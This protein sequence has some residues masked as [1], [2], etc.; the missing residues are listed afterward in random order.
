MEA[1]LESAGLS[2]SS[3]EVTFWHNVILLAKKQVAYIN[4]TKDPETMALQNFDK[5]IED[6]EV[7]IQLWTAQKKKT[8]LIDAKKEDLAS[9]EKLKSLKNS[10]DEL[11]HSVQEFRGKPS[12][13]VH[14]NEISEESDEE[15]LD[16]E[17]ITKKIQDLQEE[18]MVLK[19]YPSKYSEQISN[20][21]QEIEQLEKDLKRANKPPS[22]K[23]LQKQQAQLMQDVDLKDIAKFDE[24]K[25]D[26]EDTIKTLAKFQRQN[27]YVQ[28]YKEAQENLVKLQKI[29]DLQKQMEKYLPQILQ[30]QISTALKQLDTSM[31]QLEQKEKECQSL[32]SFLKARK[33]DTQEIENDLKTIEKI[34]QLQKQLDS[35]KP[36]VD[37]PAEETDRRT[38]I[39]KLIEKL[40]KDVGGVT[41]DELLQEMKVYVKKNFQEEIKETQKKLDTLKQ[42]QEIKI[43]L[44]S[45][46]EP[47]PSEVIQEKI[48]HLLKE[49]SF[50]SLEQ[51]L[52]EKDGLMAELLVY[53]RNVKYQEEAKAVQ[54]QLEKI[55]EIEILKAE[56]DNLPPPTQEYLIQRFLFTLKKKGFEDV[57]QLRTK[58][59]DLETELLVFRRS[60]QKFSDEIARISEE[61]GTLNKL[62]LDVPQ[63]A[64][65]AILKPAKVE[66]AKVEPAKVE[67]AKVEPA[68]AGPAKV[69]PAKAGPAKV[70]PAKAGPAKAEPAIVEP[71]NVVATKS[72]PANVGIAAVGIERVK[73]EPVEGEQ[74][75][76]ADIDET[77]ITDVKERLLKIESMPD[78][79]EKAIS[80]M[81]YKTLLKRE[82]CKFSGETKMFDDLYKNIRTDLKREGIESLNIITNL[83]KSYESISSKKWVEAVAKLDEL[84]SYYR[85]I[86]KLFMEQLLKKAYESAKEITGKDVVFLL[87]GSGAGKSTT[88]HYLAGS[89]MEKDPYTGNIM[90]KEIKNETLKE[91]IVSGAARSITRYIRAIQLPNKA[92]LCD[93][94]GFGDTAGAEVDITNGIAIIKAI[95]EANS[96][97]LLLL[98]SNKSI[99]TR[100]EGI[101]KTLKILANMMKEDSIT[102]KTLK[103]IRFVFTRFVTEEEKNYAK[104]LIKSIVA[105]DGNT[106]QQNYKN[107][108]VELNRRVID[109]NKM[110]TIDPMDEAVLK[111]KL[112][113]LKKNSIKKPGGVFVSVIN[114]DSKD[115]LNNHISILKD[116]I[117][118]ALERGT[119]SDFDYVKWK[120]DEFKWLKDNL[121]QE[122][123]VDS[124][125]NFITELSKK[126]DEFQ[127]NFN[128]ILSIVFAEGYKIK[129]TDI[130][131]LVDCLNRSVYYEKN[132]TQEHFDH[133]A[134]VTA[135]G[136][137]FNIN[138]QL[139]QNVDN[140]LK[141]DY[142]KELNTVKMSL[143][144][145]Q[146]IASNEFLI[147]SIVNTLA[148]SFQLSKEKFFE[149]KKKFSLKADENLKYYPAFGEMVKKLLGVNPN[150]DGYLGEVDANLLTELSSDLEKL[151]RNNP[152]FTDV[153]NYYNFL[154][155]F[156][157]EKID[158]Q[159]R[160]RYQL[161]RNELSE[162][163]KKNIAE[164]D[165]LIMV[166]GNGSKFENGDDPRIS[167][168]KN[169]GDRFSFLSTILSALGSH[170]DTSLTNVEKLYNERINSFKDTYLKNSSINIDKIQLLDDGTVSSIE[171][172]L[173]LMSIIRETLSLRRHISVEEIDKIREQFLQS[174][175]RLFEQFPRVVEDTM[176]SDFESD[177]SLEELFSKMN[178]LRKI[179]LVRDATNG[180]YFDAKTNLKRK[181]EECTKTI[182]SG[183]NDFSS[184]KVPTPTD[185]RNLSNSVK[186]LSS[187][188]WAEDI[189]GKGAF[190]K[191]LNNICLE[192]EYYVNKKGEEMNEKYI[193]LDSVDDLESANDIYEAFRSLDLLVS[194][195]ERSTK[196][197]DDEKSLNII[198]KVKQL[199]ISIKLTFERMI[200]SI[201]DPYYFDV[202]SKSIKG[203]DLE[204]KNLESIRDL[205]KKNVTM[206]VEEKM[207]S[208]I[209]SSELAKLQHRHQSINTMK[210]E[211]LGSVFE[212]EIEEILR[213]KV[214]YRSIG[215]LDEAIK[216]KKEKLE[217]CRTKKQDNKPMFPEE[218]SVTHLSLLKNF[219]SY[220]TQKLKTLQVKIEKANETSFSTLNALLAY[221]TKTFLP[222]YKTYLEGELVS[223]VLLLPTSIN[224]VL[225]KIGLLLDIDKSLTS[226]ESRWK[227]KLKTSAEQVVLD[228]K[229]DYSKLDTAKSWV[230]IESIYGSELNLGIQKDVDDVIKATAGNINKNILK[231]KDFLVLGNFEIISE[232]V[233]L[234]IE[235]A[236]KEI[237][238]YAG[239]LK[240]NLTGMHTKLFTSH[241]ITDLEVLKQYAEMLSKYI[242]LT[243]DISPEVK[244]LIQKDPR[245]QTFLSGEVTAII[246]YFVSLRNRICKHIED[247]CYKKAVEVIL[248]CLE[249]IKVF[250][251]KSSHFIQ[252]LAVSE[253][254]GKKETTEDTQPKETVPLSTV[255]QNLYEIVEVAVKSKV[256]NLLKINKDTLLTLSDEK[257]SPKM[258]LENCIPALD[259]SKSHTLVSKALE[260]WKELKKECIRKL[261]NSCEDYFESDQTATEIASTVKSMKTLIEIMPDEVSA[262][263]KVKLEQQ[264]TDFEAKKNK[265]MVEANDALKTLNE[266]R[267]KKVLIDIE[268]G[269]F[270]ISL[271]L[272]VSEKINLL[273]QNDIAHVLQNANISRIDTFVSSFSTLYKITEIEILSNNIMT[274]IFSDEATLIND[275]K[276]AFADI[277]QSV[278]KEISDIVNKRE[279]NEHSKCLP[280]LTKNLTLVF[281][282]LKKS[283][284]TSAANVITA[285]CKSE[286]TLL[287]DLLFNFFGGHQIS[288][289]N[290][291][292]QNS[293]E[294]LKYLIEL[295]AVWKNTAAVIKDFACT[296]FFP[297]LV[298]VVST[299]NSDEFSKK[300]KNQ[301]DK[302]HKSLVEDIGAPNRLLRI[303]R[304][305][306]D[307]KTRLLF[308]K[309]LND[310]INFLGEVEMLPVAPSDFGPKKKEFLTMFSSRLDELISVGNSLISALSE[311]NLNSSEFEE[312]DY[313]SISL[314]AISTEFP[315]FR[316]EADLAYKKY[317]DQIEVEN[318]NRMGRVCRSM[319]KKEN[320]AAELVNYKLMGEGLTLQ[321]KKIDANIDEALATYQKEHAD[322]RLAIAELATYITTDHA[323]KLI[324]GS[325]GAELVDKHP[326][327]V[328][329]KQK[330]FNE[331]V[332]KFTIDK[333]M[334]RIDGH[335]G[336]DDKSNIQHHNIRKLYANFDVHYKAILESFVLSKDKKPDPEGIAG[337]IIAAARELTMDDPDQLVFRPDFADRLPFVLANLFALWTLRTIDSYFDAGG[338]DRGYLRMPHAAQIVSILRLLGCGYTENASK[339][340][341]WS[342]VLKKRYLGLTK[343]LKKIGH[344][345]FPT[346]VEAPTTKEQQIVSTPRERIF[347][348]LIEI[349]T[350]EGESVTLAV[351][352]SV[353]ALAGADVD[354]ACYSE[355]LSGRDY[356]DFRWLFETLKIKDYVRYGT[357]NRLCEDII[358]ERGNV[359]DIVKELIINDSSTASLKEGTRRPKILLIDEVDVFFN[360]DFYGGL[361]RPSTKILK[362]SVSI[363]LDAIWAKKASLNY[364]KVK[365]MPEFKACKEDFKG[366]EFIIDEA[367]KDMLADLK[368]YKTH[369]YLVHNRKIAYK[370]QD[371]L[372]YN[373]VD[374]YKTVFAYYEEYN[375]G[376]VDK[377]GLDDLKVILIDCGAFSFADIPYRYQHIFGVTGT[378]KDLSVPEKQVLKEDYGI[379]TFTFMPSVFGDKRM[380]GRVS[381]NLRFDEKTDVMLATPDEFFFKLKDRI[382]IT[383][384]QGRPVLVFFEK[385]SELLKFAES[386]EAQDLV[387]HFNIM[388]EKLSIDEKPVFVKRATELG[389]ITLATKVYGRGTDFICRDPKVAQV[390]GMHVIQ[391]FLSLEKSEETQIMGR[392]ARQGEHGSYEMILPFGDSLEKFKVTGHL[393]KYRPNCNNLY[394]ELNARR[395]E[396]FN[397]QYTEDKKAVIEARK[398]HKAAANFMLQIFTGKMELVKEYLRNQNAGAAVEAPPSNTIVL[399]DATGSMYCLLMKS[400]T[401]V[402]DMFERVCNIL[403]EKSIAEN[404]FQLQFAVY[405]NYNSDSDRILQYSGWFSN[406]DKL[407]QFMEQI[408]V[409]GGWG[410]EA[411]EVGLRHVNNEIANGCCSQVILIGDA[412]A[413]S[414]EDINY[415]REHFGEQ[416][417]KQFYASKN[418]VPPRSYE[419]ELENIIDNGVPIHC[420]WVA[421][422]AEANFI[423]ISQ[424]TTGKYG[425][426]NIE[427]ESGG[428][429]LTDLV[430]QSVLADVG[431]KKGTGSKALVD[432]Y[433]AKYGGK[434]I[435]SL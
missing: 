226:T 174:V 434:S 351:T 305:R 170:I 65:S 271:K 187:C 189:I 405:R 105:E 113:E 213:S 327:F 251:G 346:F 43:E 244:E 138:C 328:G 428:A 208:K 320:F 307:E 407:K 286:I 31:D 258:I 7:T 201:L 163:I 339:P 369:D 253:V 395:V 243:E 144:K 221:F 112:K 330:Y 370:V 48:D 356:E 284:G 218:I 206:L 230:T 267:I 172:F 78:C 184:K 252:L 386:N 299:L 104:G 232:Q 403:K 190:K 76:E 353:L 408:S 384:K 231:L 345:V 394:Q 85:P 368:D 46:P 209:D 415:K 374:R 99:G 316:D 321:S 341:D 293:V 199:Q 34:Y 3:P 204:I 372:S 37:L 77:M 275:T 294:D 411:I 142:L 88:I 274:K 212:N 214:K 331:K 325:A 310:K 261:K 396:Q 333:V 342:L 5:A 127:S 15:A 326:V 159:I 338:N 254:K 348:N 360:K 146:F 318:K 75:M 49:L 280:S 377:A 292:E 39:I 295:V 44:K 175:N 433:V 311:K 410:E 390:N 289:Q 87:G 143:D 152:V 309:S 64:G 161:G 373:V 165:K 430:S 298:S 220:A 250:T 131:Q 108:I 222:A 182:S 98:V 83:D 176:T 26:L 332:T 135:K 380:D 323:F 101:R 36:K 406:P 109:K 28:E 420:F 102:S 319:N 397:I 282:F 235:G 92:I 94:P 128:K 383:H 8:I 17:V 93:T 296:T 416:Y 18:L 385:L 337:T 207:K 30:D 259:S 177:I 137:I 419:T 180:I 344:Y 140:I 378:L 248:E 219:L 133:S 203:R 303:T 118:N 27:K 381:T 285:N 314:K 151:P 67:P 139:K 72:A 91:F 242:S 32:L 297:K 13:S 388:T 249:Q 421:P 193:S 155:S 427:N 393:E 225:D 399:M 234:N 148:A 391:T 398:A 400:K 262:V 268:A 300:I 62:L 181:I 426:L 23:K 124:Y 129:H 136:F 202:D 103:S 343:G 278:E 4:E 216:E 56:L 365:M 350:G 287:D 125:K 315:A 324:A 14:P 158:E 10:I 82:G 236:T 86:D 256:T 12:F 186:F 52:N 404:F 179:E 367:V 134:L 111:D 121:G 116:R 247:F 317:Q 334:D 260:D 153:W 359:R 66:P 422:G 217:I 197:I 156:K 417:W 229:K 68:K 55:N 149:E 223:E 57:D 357:F 157:V 401:A 290:Y 162:L 114:P 301:L 22:I 123:L 198:Q 210:M 47:H 58:I 54:V 336:Y 169:L 371:G 245:F 389:K 2:L 347:N 119:P 224:L 246:N 276:K 340:Q 115:K 281:V 9:L 59:S 241:Y 168:F 185:I 110:E 40:E 272:N 263:I 11:E 269:K 100:G 16:P 53:R 306:S 80:I 154:G 375:S 240:T 363:L 382:N 20:S 313:C 418:Q 192:L 188:N 211:E 145:L 237:T 35:L 120:L 273:Y 132:F 413:N 279:L 431:K 96:V 435:L 376:K 126:S 424:A 233:D 312:L 81:Y 166:A 255:F 141:I 21:L 308:Y 106:G 183:I 6:C 196:S 358:N 1:I 200:Q 107:L 355:Y 71:A 387:P 402:S 291:L 19:R 364:N 95:Q 425:P 352:A 366:W 412:P 270:D 130:Q 164:I 265:L 239:Q 379:D 42:I 117:R 392:T 354:V 24:K 61:L 304:L 79:S 147:T 429:Q 409:E 73:A 122:S 89:V 60:P 257:T 160:D 150:K 283:E 90:P 29:Q 335:D 191:Q 238:N 63:E 41:E 302:I 414:E 167:N 84:L 361:Y 178:Q 51:C 288:F 45:L 50:L 362:P 205:L 432:A 228:F 97:H 227:Q 74:P 322:N 69:E 195:L 33:K 171:A 264:Q 349:G 423:E 215:E 277:V 329:W 194:T 173:K 25:A 70:E 266:E 38:E